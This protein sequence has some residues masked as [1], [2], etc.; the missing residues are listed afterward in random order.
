M[1]SEPPT[2][3][4]G[5]VLVAAGI[6][7]SRLAG[8]A[9]E[10]VI[11]PYL[12]LTPAADAFRAAAR[13]PNLLQNLFGE[14]VLSASF[15]PVYSGLLEQGR[16][17]EADRLAGAV[18][19]LLAA[20]SGV[21]ALVF[22]AFA[23]PITRVLAIGLQGEAFEL[24][25]SLVRIMTVGVAFL[26][27]A[28]WCLGVLNSHRK[29]FLSYASPV[30]WNAAQ[31]VAVL[32]GAAAG[33]STEAIAKALAAGMTVGGI[34]QFLVQVP[35]VRRVAPDLRFSVSTRVAH[36]SEVL[37]RFGP[38][39]LGRGVT[40][41]SAFVD[42]TLVSLAAAGGLAAIGTAQVLFLL[43]ISLFAMSVA[44][45]ELPELSRLA[46]RSR[47]Q[48]AIESQRAMARIMFFIL[49]SSAIYLALGDLVVDLLYE[50]G[51]F[52]NDESILVWLVLAAYSLGMPANAGSRML[53]NTLF[54]IGDTKGPARIA[55]VRITCDAALTLLLMFNLDRIELLNGTFTG[56]G[57][58][59]G[60]FGPL[61]E[62]IRTAEDVLRLGAVGC[63]LG[64]ALAAWVELVLLRRLARRE[65]GADV[66]PI[67]PIARLGVAA[68]LAFAVGAALKLVFEPLPDILRGPVVLGGAAF[69][70]VV[71]A[72]RTGVPESTLVLRPA[73]RI[74]WGR[75]LRRR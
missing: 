20:V 2:A 44:A 13:I 74:L 53:Q 47:E 59:P 69:V 40:Q 19:G 28:S 50:R 4:R 61:P 3:Q 33:W 31:I 5:S 11:Q 17:K 62:E 7:A 58:L 57:Q 66:D 12:G 24:A 52:G 27:L 14:G 34:L 10:A 46:T 9:R 51:K 39:L 60:I 64:S 29:F 70:Y 65:L 15:I 38:A 63:A 6:F 36:T 71:A 25:V 68:A 37:R 30:L 42:L 67:T 43:P 55:V 49:L 32:F 41:L 72:F 35:S 22:L 48:V 45:A 75:V 73:R 23:R 18:A 8:L 1:S 56:W 16:T 26:V 21:L 54:A